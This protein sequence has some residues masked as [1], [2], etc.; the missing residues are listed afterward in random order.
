[1]V[2]YVRPMGKI[3]IEAKSYV[4]YNDKYQCGKRWK[5]GRTDEAISAD[6]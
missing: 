5:H 3:Q 1:M 4:R 6:A 2:L